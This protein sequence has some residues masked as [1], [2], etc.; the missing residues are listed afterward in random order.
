MGVIALL[1]GWGRAA[2][3]ARDRGLSTA[4]F[5]AGAAG[6]LVFTTELLRVDDAF[7]YRLNTVFKLWLLAWVTLAA[8]AG[9]L[10]GL[11]FDRI[12]ISAQRS[13]RAGLAG[14]C[15]LVTAA[16]MLTPVAIAISRTQEGQTAGLDATAYV[17]IDLPGIGSAAA[18]ARGALDPRDNVVLQAIGDSY[19]EGNQFS[20]LSGVPT[21][22]GWP[23][24][25]QQWRGDVDVVG[26]RNETDRIYAGE[27][28]P[29][30]VAQR[31]G[32][33]HVYVGVRE[34][35]EYGAGTAAR[36]AAWSVAYRDEY[37]TVFEVPEGLR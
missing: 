33:T 29:V 27:D 6:T 31:A 26:R 7:D 4:L 30:L 9:A 11:A 15:A 22:L 19:S 14:A 17:E 1:A 23:G 24:H 25:E 13:W 10:A 32:V 2:D 3:Q 16:S 5:L 18:W 8:S 37:G 12:E 35:D 21:L 20:V 28:D 34:R 36:F